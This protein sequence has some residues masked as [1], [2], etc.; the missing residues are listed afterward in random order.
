MN[1]Y[2]RELVGRISSILNIGEKSM[3]KFGTKSV[4]RLAT[5]DVRLQE[6]L[7][8]AI[9]FIDFSVLCG[10]RGEADQNKAFRDGNSKL[11]YP[12]SKHNSY[13]SLAVDIAPY[14]I[15]WDDTVRF[16]H[17]IGIMRGIA[18]MKGYNLRVGID[19]DADGEIRDHQFLDFPHIE[20]V[21]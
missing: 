2:F 17:L 21:D 14:P 3:Y 4:S 20:L 18:R 8:E 10:H 15:D 5:C 1:N 11:P 6:I 12:N 13:P 19:W 16:A 7:N 9:K